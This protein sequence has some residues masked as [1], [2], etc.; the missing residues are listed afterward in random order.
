MHN[1]SVPEPLSSHSHLIPAHLNHTWCLESGIP[2]TRISNNGKKQR[3]A[4]G[5]PDSAHLMIYPQSNGLKSSQIRV[6][7]VSEI[8][9][10]QYLEPQRSKLR[11]CS[12]EALII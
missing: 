12:R 10:S 1:H 11:L 3:P 5:I 7:A 9:L 4:E 2:D 8:T 6:D